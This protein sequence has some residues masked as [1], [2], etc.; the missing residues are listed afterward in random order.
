MNVLHE[1][2]A[3]L[4]GYNLGCDPPLGES[5]ML[6][7]VFRLDRTLGNWE[8]DLPLPLSLLQA[9]EYT[10]IDASNTAHLRF[11]TI[12]TLRKLNLETLIHRPALIQT[13]EAV[14]NHSSDATTSRSVQRMR[15]SSISSCV[16]AA[17]STIYIIHQVTTARGPK[18][19]LLG[20][21][22]FSL[23]F[24]KSIVDS[25]THNVFFILS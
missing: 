14:K 4:Y 24:G 5:E 9:G 23:Y 21:W 12:L 25:G 20:A 16:T 2:I 8:L 7:R 10:N 17:E 15:Q 13:M 1:V 18:N 11:R 3:D 22:W 19:R 6:D